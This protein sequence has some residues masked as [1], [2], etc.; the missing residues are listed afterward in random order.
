[1]APISCMLCYPCTSL[2]VC[3]TDAGTYS[4]RR[5]NVLAAP[6]LPAGSEILSDVP[7]Q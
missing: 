4:Y 1:M 6:M 7:K 2:C 3:D 5:N